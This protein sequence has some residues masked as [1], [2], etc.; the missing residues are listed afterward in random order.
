MKNLFKDII[1]FKPRVFDDKRGFFFEAY[2]QEMEETLQENFAQDNHSF[3]HENVIRGLHYQWDK[4][5]GKLIRV[6]RGTIRDYFVD[7]RKNSSTYGRYDSILL[8]E[9]NNI[10]TWVPAGFAHGFEVLEGSA[11]ILYKCSEFYNKEGESGINPFD[12]QINIPWEIPRKKVIVSE[13]DLNLKTF[14]EYSV[15][16]KF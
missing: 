11:T 4:P 13:R 1:T 2:S 16:P 14:A 15:D 6:V 12:T 9:K 5:M 3:S 8:S 7:I 10:C